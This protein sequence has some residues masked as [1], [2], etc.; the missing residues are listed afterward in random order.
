MTRS[1]D[2]I[3]IG[4]DMAGVSAANKCASEGLSVNWGDLMKH[5]HGT[6]GCL[7]E[8]VA[9]NAEGGQFSRSRALVDRPSTYRSSTGRAPLS[10]Y[11]RTPLRHA[12]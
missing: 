1:Y 3:V 5:T 10:A 11:R 9:S 7:A 12:L 8:A 2:L 4:A 6:H